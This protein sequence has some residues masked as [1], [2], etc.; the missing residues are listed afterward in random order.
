MLACSRLQLKVSPLKY[1]LVFTVK[2]AK[3]G[4]LNCNLEQFYYA[5]FSK[6]IKK[7]RPNRAQFLNINHVTIS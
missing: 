6:K 2:H 7:N 3:N 4:V 1:R 5:L